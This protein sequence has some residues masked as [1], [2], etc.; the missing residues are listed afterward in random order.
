MRVG[1]MLS[2]LSLTA[3]D[4]GKDTYAMSHPFAYKA[5]MEEYF[6]TAENMVQSNNTQSCVEWV[7]LCIDDGHMSVCSGPQGT[8]QI[9]SVGAYKRDAGAK[10]LEQIETEFTQ[11]MG[12]MSKYD[13]FFEN[14]MGMLTTDLDHYITAFNNGGVPYFASTFTDAA[15]NKKY[16]SVLV[17][18]PGS[19]APSAKSL[20]NVEILAA[21]SSLLDAR[22]DLHHHDSPRASSE[23]LAAAQSHLEA[24]PRKLGAN[25]NPVMAKLHRSFASSDISRDSQYFQKALQGTISCDGSVC[26]GKMQQTDTTEFRYVAASSTQG[27]TSVA[28]Y[29]TYQVNLHNTCF[30]SEAN[31]GFD[32]LAD[33]HFGHNLGGGALDAYIKGQKSFGL[34]YRFYGGGGSGGGVNQF[35]YM[36]APNGWGA[37]VIGSCTDSSLCPSRTGGYNMCTQ[38]IKGHCSKDS[39]SVLV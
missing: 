26:E 4:F 38:G 34:P 27:P 5:F 30:D 21:T 12:D 39:S 22:D 8:F 14:H 35:F 1:L 37:Q 17:Q 18:V 20:L 9:H 15:T 33:N 28:A 2:T 29:E 31:D 6:P 32:R 19:L 25:G 3:A 10:S 36:Y 11:S 7:K 13:P 16:K 23:S 24:A